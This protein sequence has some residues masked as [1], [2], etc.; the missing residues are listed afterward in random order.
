MCGASFKACER[1]EFAIAFDPHARKYWSEEL[2]DLG[3]FDFGGATCRPR[4]FLM[5]VSLSVNIVYKRFYNVTLARCPVQI[6]Q[7]ARFLV[8]YL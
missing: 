3:S 2:G 4:L 1:N 6:A 5:S 8:S 7:L